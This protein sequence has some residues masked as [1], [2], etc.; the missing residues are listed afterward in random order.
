[1]PDTASNIIV[2]TVGNTAN[3]ATDFGTSGVNLADA[4]IPLQKIAY[5][6][7]GAAIRVSDTNPLPI[8]VK[9]SSVAITVSGL[10]GP[11]GEFGIVNSGNKYLR[12]A[13]TSAG[14]GIT[15]QGEVG[16]TALN[17]SV[18]GGIIAGLKS[19]RDTV[20]I[21]GGT[22]EIVGHN[23]ITFPAAKIFAGAGGATGAA[24]GISGDAMKVAVV[25]AG[26]TAVVSLSATVGVTNNGILKV[27]G[28]GNFATPVG[29]TLQPININS[30]TQPSGFTNGQLNVLS[31]GRQLP[32]A[33]LG[34]GVKL[35]AVSTNT[36][37]IYLG[38]TF[39][40][41]GTTNGYPL[42]AGESC[43]LEVNNLNLVNVVGGATG[44]L[45]A[46][47]GS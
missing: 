37:A 35:R 33:P 25:N 27:A 32:A 23:G 43:F 31:T 42:L 20:K 18:T 19:S 14:G 9:G 46:Y 26:F 5:G 30:I 7:S 41:L 36:S 38:H 47:L 44:Q 29:A 34:S 28:D 16:I 6:N 22:L 2:Q 45:I 40:P 10:V 13:G 39:N 24:V 1:M 8:E 21:Q 15:V 3:L 4:H 17:L 11:S 12:V